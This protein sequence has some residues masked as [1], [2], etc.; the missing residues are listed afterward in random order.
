V[1]LLRILP[2]I[3]GFAQGGPSLNS[4]FWDA[5]DWMVIALLSVPSAEEVPMEHVVFFPG[6]DAAPS[7]RRFSSLDEAVRFVEHLRNVEGVSE[8]SV[9][10]LT[11]VPLAFRPYYRVEVPSGEAAPV[12]EPVAEPTV[13]VPAP[14]EPVAEETVAEPMP[15]AEPALVDAGMPA[16]ESSPNGKRSLGFL[17][18]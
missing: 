4:G 2:D 9:H 1:V 5:D 13:D 18:H 12:A 17:A 14:A 15:V 16:A 10:V 7:F 3:A 8:V 11:P 6:P